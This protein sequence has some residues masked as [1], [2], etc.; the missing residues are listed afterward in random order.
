[1]FRKFLRAT[2]SDF[3]HVAESISYA[4]YKLPTQARDVESSVNSHPFEALR[5]LGVAIAE[6][7]ETPK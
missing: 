3:A 7:S 4:I 6:G 1:V 2:T 5:A